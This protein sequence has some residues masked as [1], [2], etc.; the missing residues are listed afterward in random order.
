MIVV[1]VI[2]VT[3]VIIALCMTITTATTLWLPFPCLYVIFLHCT[4]PSYS[5]KFE[6]QATCIANGFTMLIPSP[7]GGLIRVAVAAQQPNSSARTLQKLKFKENPIKIGLKS[8]ILKIKQGLVEGNYIS[9][10]QNSTIQDRTTTFVKN[11]NKS[12]QT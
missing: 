6:V 4:R 10:Q 7:K 12:H 1:I 3:V 9:K 5:M 8:K 2:V 11:E